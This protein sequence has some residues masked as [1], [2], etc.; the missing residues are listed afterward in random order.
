VKHILEPFF[1]R[2]GEVTRLSHRRVIG[3]IG[4]LESGAI[5]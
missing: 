5:N 4:H 3:S 1:V 2:N